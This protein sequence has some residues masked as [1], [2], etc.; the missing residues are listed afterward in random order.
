[1]RALSAVAC[2]VAKHCMAL[3]SVPPLWH[4]AACPCATVLPLLAATRPGSAGRHTCMRAGRPRPPAQR[5]VLPLACQPAAP[6]VLPLVPRHATEAGARAVHARRGGHLDGHVACLDLQ[7]GRGAAGGRAR[8]RLVAQVV[9]GSALATACW[10]GVSGAAGVS[11]CMQHLHVSALVRGSGAPVQHGCAAPPAGVCDYGTAC[12]RT[13]CAQHTRGHSVPSLTA[14]GCLTHRVEHFN[15]LLLELRRHDGGAH[16]HW[17][18][19]VC[20]HVTKAQV[21]LG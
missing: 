19:A 17:G 12:L 4:A 14:S 15:E 16:V 5:D 1:M 7:G 11:C 9:H 10:E 21:E 18:G 20:L 8:Q 6:L 3:G 13:H 2:A